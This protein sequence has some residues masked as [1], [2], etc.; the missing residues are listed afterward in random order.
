MTGNIDIMLIERVD[1]QL[2]V[3][4][5][6]GVAYNRNIHTHAHANENAFKD[7]DVQM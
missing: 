5:S 3:D 6:I 4:V 2:N 1:A 7:E